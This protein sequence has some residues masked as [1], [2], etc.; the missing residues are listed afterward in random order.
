MLPSVE[1]D[2]TFDNH[3]IEFE[4][5]RKWVISPEGREAKT[6]NPPGYQNVLLHGMAHF[7]QMQQAM[8]AQQQ[9]QNPQPEGDGANQPKAKEPY[10]KNA[11]ITGDNNVATVQ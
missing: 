11:P 8:M 7:A 10:N 5:V 9:M 6:N 4:V 3:K 2:P 1:I